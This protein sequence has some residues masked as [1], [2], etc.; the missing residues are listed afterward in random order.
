[1]SDCR[2]STETVVLDARIT[3]V[4]AYSIVSSSSVSENIFSARFSIRKAPTAIACARSG[5][6]LPGF[7]ARSLRLK[8]F[9]WTIGI[10]RPTCWKNAS[11][12]RLRILPSKNSKWIFCDCSCDRP[13]DECSGARFPGRQRG[14]TL[15]RFRAGSR[16][17]LSAGD[18]IAVTKLPI[19]E[20]RF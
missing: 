17:V 2:L 15:A 16:D 9:S 10:Q 5:R 19:F 11:T 20:L 12:N 14:S 8:A 6:V 1:M 13:I 3:L 18:N 4:I 7:R